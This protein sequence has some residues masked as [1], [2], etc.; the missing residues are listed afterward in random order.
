MI[1]VYKM[2]Y[3]KSPNIINRK[4]SVYV[5]WKLTAV[6]IMDSI[7]I[8]YN[9]N[10]ILLIIIPKTLSYTTKQNNKRRY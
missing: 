9:Y 7:T 4:E 6:S 10:W 5:I 2:I 1:I 3:L 8:I